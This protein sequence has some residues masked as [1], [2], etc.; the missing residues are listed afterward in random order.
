[1]PNLLQNT[2]VRIY[3]C[4]INTLYIVMNSNFKLHNDVFEAIKR[5]RD[6]NPLSSEERETL[7]ARLRISERL[8]DV[9]DDELYQGY[10]LA[11]V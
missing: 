2:N 9:T 8:S 11:V 7:C 5:E 4:N 1:M 10:I 6:R 3:C